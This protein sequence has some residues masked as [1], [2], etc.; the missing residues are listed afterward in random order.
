VSVG[1]SKKGQ[2]AGGIS[3]QDAKGRFICPIRR[4]THE[5]HLFSERPPRNCCVRGARARPKFVEIEQGNFVLCFMMD[6][7]RM[8]S[9]KFG[10]NRSEIDTIGQGC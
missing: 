1:T 4:T 3:A 2:T 5:L 10:E 6:A 7:R 9:S 8:C